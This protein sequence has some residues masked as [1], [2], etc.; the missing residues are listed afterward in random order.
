MPELPDVTVYVEALAARIAGQRLVGV[1][2]ASPFLLRSVDPP[3]STAGGRLVACVRRLG[4]RVVIDLEGDLH[5]VLHLMIAGRL[6]WKPGPAPEGRRVGR[7]SGAEPRRWPI[8]GR[9]GLAAFDFSNGTVVLT[10]AG[11]KKRA[12]LHL[13]DGEAALRQ[14]DAGGVEV[15][16]ADLAAFRAALARERHTLKRSLTDP[17][18]FS[19]IGNAYSD[20]ILHRARLSPIRLT[21][22]LHPEEVE[23]LYDATRVTLLDW[24]G[25][26][27]TEAGT[28][29]PEKVTAFRAGMA[30]HGRYGQPCPDCGAPVQRIVHAENETNYCPRCQTG[31]R[32]LADRALS[33]L[34]RADW[35]R[36][37]EE[38]EERRGTNVPPGPAK[39]VVRGPTRSRVRTKG[40]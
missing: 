15:L 4:K 36:T 23:R 33:R 8:P 28:G 31:G 18:L 16:E 19:G 38:L 14:L 26:L 21:D 25:R 35:P 13:V 3:L 20:E 9:L 30:V 6:H 22:G 5:L 32:L 27:R 34:L 12:A 2:V 24:I 10:E 1:R 39:V 17:T 40:S 37:L 29:F 11:T 7:M